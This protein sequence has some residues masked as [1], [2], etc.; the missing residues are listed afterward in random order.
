MIDDRTRELMD[1]QRRHRDDDGDGWPVLDRAARHG[2]AGEFLDAVELTTEADPAGVLVQFLGA[3]GAVIGSRPDM[4][5]ANSEHPA[6]IDAVLVGQTAKARKT[7][8]WALVTR[9]V[10]RAVPSFQRRVMA[11]FNSAESLID[12]VADPDDDGDGGVELRDRRLL[13]VEP[14]FARLLVVC[15]REGSTLSAVL[16]NAY[17]GNRLE[18]RSRKS[19]TTTA[20]GAHVVLL[21]HITAEELTRTLTTTEA[22]NGFANRLL[23][24]LVRR[25]RRL[26]TGSNVPE[27]LVA[28]FA[29]QLVQVFDGAE[30]IREM[31]WRPDALP[32][33][34]RLY[35]EMADDEPPGLL[36]AIVARPEAH[37]MRLA[38]T[39]ALL[40]NESLI[41]PE[42]LRAAWAVWSYSRA[43]AEVI[44]ADLSGDPDVDRL[45]AAVR[46]AGPDGL[47]G[48]ALN[49]FFA[50]HGKGA[51]VRARAQSRGLVRTEERSSGGRPRK[52]VVL[53]TPPTPGKP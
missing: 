44:F 5:A 52:V 41:A 16:R 28:S 49:H 23:Y 21:G 26:P 12:A 42:H 48:D 43:S 9:V 46:A 25:Q 40:D 2:L 34:E 47:D 39:Y 8:G 51:K 31:T 36:G 27:A 33:W 4:H 35:D 38:V 50:G 18:V 14:E 3:V 11:G 10:M 1:A 37:V 32:L 30:R 19:G 13:V 45:L 6:R 53:S 22:A 17:D 15:Q 29:A 7:S 20:T 24:I